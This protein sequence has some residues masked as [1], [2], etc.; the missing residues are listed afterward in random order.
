MLMEV[1]HPIAFNPNAVLHDEAEKRGWVVVLERKDGIYVLFNGTS[2]RFRSSDE[3]E[4]L[5]AVM[6]VL[7]LPKQK[8]K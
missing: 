5:E 2:R 1:D 6:Y 4:A 8:R 3:N 7:S